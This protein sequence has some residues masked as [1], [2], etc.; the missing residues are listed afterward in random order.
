MPALATVSHGTSGAG[1]AVAGGLVLAGL[2]AVAANRRR[3]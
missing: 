2:V 1:A 3:A